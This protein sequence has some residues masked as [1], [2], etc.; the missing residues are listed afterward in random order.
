MQLRR[1]ISVEI[2]GKTYT[3]NYTH[4]KGVATVTNG[5]AK[6]ATHAEGPK[7]YSAKQ[8]QA[9]QAELN[10]TTNISKSPSF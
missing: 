2:E 9:T 3:A 5:F 1:K 4:E 6:R 7:D 10:H 8:N